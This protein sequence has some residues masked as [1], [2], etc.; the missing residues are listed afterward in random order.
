[1][2]GFLRDC[3]RKSDLGTRATSFALARSVISHHLINLEGEL[4]TWAEPTLD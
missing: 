4:N 1:M 3:L 2:C